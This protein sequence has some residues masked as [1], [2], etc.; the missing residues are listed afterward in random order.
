M[1]LLGL[2]S[3]IEWWAELNWKIRITIPV[4]LIII[5]TILLLLGKIWIWGWIF[6]VTLLLAGGPSN[7]EKKG[8]KF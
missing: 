2:K 4:I 1:N 8:Y 6:G 3:L 5:S 7:S